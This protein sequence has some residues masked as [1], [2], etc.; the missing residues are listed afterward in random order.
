MTGWDE[1]SAQSTAVSHYHHLI[2][3][4][5]EVSCMKGLQLLLL[6]NNTWKT[7]KRWIILL[8]GTVPVSTDK[9][10]LGSYLKTMTDKSVVPAICN[11]SQYSTKFRVSAW[12]NSSHRIIF[13]GVPVK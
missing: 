9:E 3:N 11:L 2:I 10:F 6:E 1:W 7:M 8:G 12:N 4:L 13:P 5:Q